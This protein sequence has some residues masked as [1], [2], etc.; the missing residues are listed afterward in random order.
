MNKI[1]SSAVVLLAVVASPL[2]GC[3]SESHS[4]DADSA[5]S[6][7]K[8]PTGTFSK[9]TG[10]SAF[11]SYQSEHA[12]SDSVSRPSVGSGSSGQSNPQSVKVLAKTLDA[13]SQ[14]TEGEKCACAGGG[15]AIYDQEPSKIG[16]AVRFQFDKCIGDD[17][18]G[19]DG[20][21]LLLVTSQPIVDLAK[22]TPA[23]SGASADAQNI[24]FAAKGTATDGDKSLELEF[25]LVEESG[26]TL[27]AVEVADG[28][29]V[30]GL[31]PDGSAWVKAKQGTWTCKPNESKSYACTPVE[32]DGEA[33]DVEADPSAPSTK[34]PATDTAGL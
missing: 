5:L 29:I 24:L 8:N 7:F 9:D 32:G 14:C 25:A 11:S 23:A 1:M 26:Y 3:S 10:S 33:V 18:A 6:A 28:K 20:E 2:M 27:L 4:V 15:S 19:F 13:K 12:Q 31:A 34:A 30:V 22:D 17:G 21:A 16:K